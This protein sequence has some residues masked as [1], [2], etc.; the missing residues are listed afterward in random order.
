MA[1]ISPYA[2][3]QE[4]D[5]NGNPLSGGKLYTYE[6][7]TTT[8]KPT[9]TDSSG[10]TENDNPI[11][12]DSN[13]RADVWL[14]SGAYKFVLKDLNDVL[15]KEVDNVAGESTNQLGSSIVELSSNTAISS[16]YLFNYIDCTESI[17]LTLLSASVAEEGFTFIVKN[18]SNGTVIIDPDGSET[19]DGEL[20]LTLNPS[21]WS[22]VFCDGVSWKT[23]TKSN[24]V[25]NLSATAPPTTSD[26]NTQGYS[27]S[28]RWLDVT[29][30]EAYVCLDASTG[31]AVWLET[32][33]TSDDLGAAA[34]KG[35]D[36]DFT[37]PT[38]DSL[39]TTLA[40]QN[41]ITSIYSLDTEVLTTT[42]TQ[43]DFSIP[44][45]AKKIIVMMNDMGLDGT[46]DNA[47]IQIGD[48]GGVETTGYNSNSYDPSGTG[49]NIS[50]VNGFAIANLS[51]AR[52]ATGAMVLDKKNGS[53]EWVS[54]H[55]AFR[56]DRTI[57]GAGVKALS[58]E[59]TTLRI[60]RSG[61][62][63]FDSGSVNIAVEVS[64]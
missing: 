12:L 60:T 3:F 10:V 62:A 26:D 1:R 17:A 57:S 22:I 53:N 38:D 35:V 25:N 42:G 43:F 52:T 34:V 14:E 5:N 8:P 48:S 32:T 27:I 11:T 19:I 46:A 58:D 18:S 4:L 41:K 21:D 47:L 45:N 37:S 55:T 23:L 36:T 49:T 33:L 24:V 28:S 64:E 50:S 51:A 63:S 61:T 7:G 6:A 15:V 54:T 40:V 56:S 16:S 44:A 9:Y 13:G 20:T 31:A 2:F 59:I 39:P 29:N 30:D